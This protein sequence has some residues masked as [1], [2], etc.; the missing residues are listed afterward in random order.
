MDRF[1]DYLY[2]IPWYALVALCAIIGGTIANIVRSRH[3][4]VERMELIKRGKDPGREPL[5]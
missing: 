1:F 3:R 5:N 4:H 2:A